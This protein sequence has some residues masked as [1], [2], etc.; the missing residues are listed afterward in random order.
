MI[1][2]W[3]SPGVRVAP[4]ASAF[5]EGSLHVAIGFAEGDRYRYYVFVLLRQDD[6]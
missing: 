6:V 4:S 3:L 5:V 1:R 2:A